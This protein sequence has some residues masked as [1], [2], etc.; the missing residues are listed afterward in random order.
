MPTWN[1]IDREV[2]VQISQGKEP[3]LACD[4]IRRAHLMAL[5]RLTGRAVIAYYSGFLQKPAH[6]ELAITD[7]DMNGLM[8]VTHQLPR[9]NGLDLI[10][11]TPGGAIEAARALVEYIYSMFDNRDVRVIVPQLAMSAGTM[12]ACAG[13]SILMGKHSSLGPTDPQVSGLPALGVLEEIDKAISEIKK[14]PARQLFWQEIFRKYPPAFISNCERSVEGTRQ[15]V[16][17][18]L[19]GN[20]LSDA[21]DPI[22]AA[23]SVV[24]NLMN[25][26]ETT[27]HG[28]HFLKSK[29]I[30]F[31]LNV[32]S[33]EA[34]QKLQEAVLS[35][36]HCYVAS[37]ARS[38][39]VK[40][41][42]NSIGASW[43]V[44]A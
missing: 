38:R 9:Q 7:F 39:T 10:L 21:K 44:A 30:E 40:F 18:W 28:H 5:S 42:E 1:E 12:I 3:Q 37:F 13:R 24:D 8:A 34:D 4:E 11:H 31:G 20:M 22:V 41:I 26:K 14:D 17:A 2:S 19:A 43:N 33:L 15:M 27:E 6:P 32:E 35:V 36:H 16:R 29:C 23:E 25:Y